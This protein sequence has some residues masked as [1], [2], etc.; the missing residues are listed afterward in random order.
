MWIITRKN[1]TFLKCVQYVTDFPYHLIA[2]ERQC[3][4]SYLQLQSYRV[5]I[6]F[7]VDCAVA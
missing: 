7:K 3:Q 4:A 5:S 2:K 1:K 6:Q